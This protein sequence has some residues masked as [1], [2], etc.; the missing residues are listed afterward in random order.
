[1]TFQEFDKKLQAVIIKL[2]K[3][4]EKNK[5]DAKNSIMRPVYTPISS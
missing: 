4:A 5:K 3:D 1:M 2:Q